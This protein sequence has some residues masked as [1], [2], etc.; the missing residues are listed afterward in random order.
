MTSPV[1]PAVEAQPAP[2]APAQPGVQTPAAK[3]LLAFADKR[4][5]ELSRGRFAEERE[6]Y[7]AAL[8]DQLKQWL[9]WDTS[10]RRFKPLEQNKQKPVPMPVSNYFSKT[11]SANANSLG[12][13]IPEI[14]VN[15][16]DDDPRNRRAAEAA[17]KCAAEIDEES[18]MEFLNTKLARHT[19][20]FGLGCT[21]DMIDQSQSAD[22]LLSIGIT[23][24]EVGPD[25]E[26]GES[27]VE[28]AEPEQLPKGKITTEICSPFEI[29]LPRDC[30]DPNLSYEV[31]RRKRIQLEKAK[32]SYPDYADQFKADQTERTDTD[33]SRFLDDA[34]KYLVYTPGSQTEMVSFHEQW[35][36][37]AYLGKEVKDEL[38]KEWQAEPSQAYPGMTRL[39]A[40]MMY[41]VFWLIADKCVIQYAENPWT[42]YKPF[43][44]YPW[45]KDVGSP[46]PKGLSTELVP[47]QKQLNRLDSYMELASMANGGGKWIVSKNHMNTTQFTGNP[48][49]V[50]W[51]NETSGP[52]PTFVQPS[53]Y[54]PALQHRRESLLQDFQE[55]G[56]TSGVETG[57]DPSGGPTAFRA[58]AFLGAKAEEA[59]KTQRYLWEQAH[60]LRKRKVLLM[61]QRAWDEPRKVKVSG[62]NGRFSMTEFEGSDLTGDYTIQVVTDSSQPK[63]LSDRLQSVQLEIQAGMIDPQDPMTREV[64]HDWL[65]NHE[66]NLADHLQIEKAERDLESLRKGMRPME[67]PFQKWDVFLKI[68]ANYTLTEEFAGLDPQTQMGILLYTQYISDKLT[69]VSMPPPGMGAPGAPGGPNVPGQNPLDQVPGETAGIGATQQ[70]AVKEG[71]NVASQITPAMAG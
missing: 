29:F 53:P 49:D 26:E 21:Q 45:Q 42:I 64:I 40:A 39:Q 27:Q 68:F 4:F 3:A 6:W 63:T 37:W 22:N 66:L 65:G 5:L 15:P 56:Y 18:G 10:T 46:Y 57:D 9:E 69:A 32:A 38:T 14:V 59:R 60:E 28:S 70:A 55:L 62:Y 36:D 67:S 41:G 54:S 19:V 44:F 51:Y 17:Q 23:P 8:F 52:P 58:L 7:Q 43:T 1:T 25:G 12:A 11:I 2:Q 30:S 34:L 50:A 71:N 31:I 16:D 13:Q 61:A 47:L 20:L 35:T 33:L 24:G 48:I